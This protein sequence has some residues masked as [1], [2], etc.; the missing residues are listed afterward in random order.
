MEIVVLP[1]GLLELPHELCRR[2]EIDAGARF[3]I[4]IDQQQGII[5]LKPISFEDHSV[6]LKVRKIKTKVPARLARHKSGA[7]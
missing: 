3:E 7:R 2:M 6:M 5:T 4:E 1:N